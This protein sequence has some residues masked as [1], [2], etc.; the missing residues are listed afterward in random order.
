MSKQLTT[1]QVA[2]ILGC[3]EARI[4]RAVDRLPGVERF[5]GK[6][7]IPREMLPVI[8]DML[9]HRPVAQRKGFA[10]HQ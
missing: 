5:A 6:R 2:E 8:L 3:H 9:H 7:V 4:R 10:A 1:K